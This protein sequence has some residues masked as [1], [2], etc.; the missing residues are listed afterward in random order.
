MLRWGSTART[1]AGA[2]ESVLMRVSTKAGR[3]TSAQRKA[4]ARKKRCSWVS[5]SIRPGSPFSSSAA[6]IEA[7]TTLVEGVRDL[8]ADGAADGSII[9]GRVCLV[10][11]V[12]RLQD[13]GREDDL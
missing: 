7:G 3:A 11:E 6:C 1:E 8:M 5:P 9:V 2:W 12:G 4:W 13:G 10:I